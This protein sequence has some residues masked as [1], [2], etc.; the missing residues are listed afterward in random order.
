MRTIWTVPT[1]S[2]RQRLIAAGGD[3]EL[4][5]VLPPS[6][7]PIDNHPARRRQA[8]EELGLAPDDFALLA[9]GEMIREVNHKMACWVHAIIRHVAP[10]VRLVLPNPGPLKDSIYY[11]ASGAGSTEEILGPWPPSHR[12]DILAAGDAAVFFAQRDCGVTALVEALAAGLP[13]VAFETPDL[14]ECAGPAALLA[15]AC[16]PRA[17]SKAVLSLLE[18]PGL[19]DDVGQAGRSRAAEQFT[20]SLAKDALA[21]AYEAALV[22]AG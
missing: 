2:S 16:T 1:A 4:I 15:E 5:H 22:G 10:R 17:G 13:V 6:A 11:F 7:E 8:R 14:V 20:V 9:P 19:A 18:T 12:A 3:A 21:G